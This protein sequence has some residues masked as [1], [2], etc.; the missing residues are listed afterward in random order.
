VRARTL[1][2]TGALA[3]A[4]T[5]GSAGVAHGIPAHADIGDPC[6]RAEL[7][8][9]R[10][11]ARSDQQDER[12]AHLEARLAAAVAAGRERLA[13]RLQDQLDRLAARQERVDLRILD[14]EAWL[15]ENCDTGT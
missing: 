8:M 4:L 3:T 13:E 6:E 7:R 2:T 1:I 12:Q 5:V 10:L 15:S 9:D 11:V 14:L